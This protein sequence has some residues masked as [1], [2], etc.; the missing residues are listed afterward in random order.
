MMF[1]DLFKGNSIRWTTNVRLQSD[2]SSSESAN[3]KEEQQL[4]DEETEYETDIKL[5]ILDAS[6][7]YVHTS[8]WSKQALAEGVTK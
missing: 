7:T 4:K 2:D 8:G 5:K 3:K 6:L 1:A